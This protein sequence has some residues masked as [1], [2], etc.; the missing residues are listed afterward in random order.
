MPVEEYFFWL[1]RTVRCNCIYDA[2]SGIIPA[3]I[4][5]SKISIT[6]LHTSTPVHDSS[7]HYRNQHRKTM[8][9]PKLNN[10]FRLSNTQVTGVT[11]LNRSTKRLGHTSFANNVHK[12]KHVRKPPSGQQARSLQDHKSACKKYWIVS[13]Y[14]I[15]HTLLT[16][17]TL[18]KSHFQHLGILAKAL[19]TAIGRQ[20]WLLSS[21]WF[22]S[23]LIQSSPEISGGQDFRLYCVVSIFSR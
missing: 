8:Q 21:W 23:L 12:S 15:F 14:M 2:L 7:I 5:K 10:N 18:Q 17:Q 22:T 3:L 1:I 16:L 20:R 6:P 19:L 11:D 13:L 4:Q 9:D